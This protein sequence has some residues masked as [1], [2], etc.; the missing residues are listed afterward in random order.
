MKISVVETLC[1]AIQPNVLFVRLYTDEGMVGLGEAF[2]DAEAVES[3]L[4]HSLAPALCALPDATP[5]WAAQSLASYVGFQGGG[6]E[7]RARGA[8]D[9]ALWDLLGRS[10][11]L[12]VVRLLGG[13]V[14]D[15]IGIYNT[16]A[17]S[18]YV[19]RSSRQVMDNWGLG[20]ESILDDLR[21]FLT[22]P[23]ELARELRHEGIP[24][25]KVWPFDAA[26]E[27]SGGQDISRSELAKGVGV[28]EQIRDAVGS[29]MDIM[30]E[31]HGL[32]NRRA[33]T[34][35]CDALA[36]Y[37]IY[38]VEDPIRPDAVDALAALHADIDIP[39]ATGETC[40]GR[41]GFL[42]LLERAAVDVVTCDV[43]WTGGL[44]EA[45]KIAA[46]ADIYGV[47]IAPHDCTGPVTFAACC[48]LSLSQPNALIQETV[49]AFRHTWYEE[50]V[51]GVPQVSG[52]VVR[53]GET[54]GLGV[55]LREDAMP[56]MRV[57]RTDSGA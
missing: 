12:P 4:H 36:P 9:L 28:I 16:C 3:Y 2:Y 8:I 51:T 6:V 21:A 19:S 22:R 46:L 39:L 11:G 49:R 48:H 29:D 38:W 33:A 55:E 43:Q 40:V 7:T 13:P 26:A 25:M 18:G 30:V 45:R 52:G 37:G 56:H 17:G 34:K 32:W 57:R 47:P 1:P 41:R 54:P 24:A 31:L 15:A 5:E 20:S 53:V 14:R 27:R 10:T 42:P 50:L 44:T 23:G 35:I